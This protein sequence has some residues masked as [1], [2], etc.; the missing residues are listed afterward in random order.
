MH[1]RINEILT[2]EGVVIEGDQRGRQ[3]GFP[4][5][6]VPVEDAVSNEMAIIRDGVYVT[7]FERT[8][9]TRL[10]ATTSVGHR[11]TFYGK[12]AIRLIE[13][14]VLDF[15]GNLYGEHVRVHFMHRLRPQRAFDGVPTLI[16]QLERDVAETR[17]WAEELKIGT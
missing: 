17:S 10:L 3:L 16:S 2:L 13:V 12:D 6:N 8:D 7:W 5:A 4:T 9:G 1:E 15:Q 11:P 14:H